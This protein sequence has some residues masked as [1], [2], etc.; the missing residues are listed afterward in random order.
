MKVRFL[1]NIILAF[2]VQSVSARRETYQH[3]SALLFLFFIISSHVKVTRNCYLHIFRDQLFHTSHASTF[4]HTFPFVIYC[5]SIPLK[6]VFISSSVV[7]SPSVN[8]SVCAKCN[9]L[10]EI[11]VSSELKS[12][13]AMFVTYVKT[14]WWDSSAPQLW[15]MYL[16]SYSVMFYCLQQIKIIV[17]VAKCCWSISLLIQ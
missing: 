15:W 5:A 13:H 8:V 17:P 6:S 3:I 14:W 2:S 16:F 1:E 12:C 10:L 7:H 9:R 11:T 4:K